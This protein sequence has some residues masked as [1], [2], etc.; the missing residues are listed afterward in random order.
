MPI[1][2]A[3]RKE[4]PCKEWVR[5][6]QRTGLLHTVY[7]VNGDEY[8]GEW[9]NDKRHGRGFMKYSKTG[10]LYEG[11]WK[12]DLKDGYG[13]Y[14]LP[15]GKDGK[16]RKVY[17]GWW[18]NDK[19]HGFGV[20]YR[21]ETEY[22]E[23]EWF[24]GKHSGWGHMVD[25]KDQIYEGEWENGLKH[26]QGMLRLSNENRYEGEF[27]NGMKNGRGSFYFLDTGQRYDGIWLNDIPKCG[28]VKDYGRSSATKP[29]HYIIRKCEL[30]DLDE[31]VFDAEDKF[32]QEVEKV[33]S[34]QD[35]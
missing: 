31:V 19:R 5:K 30:R 16:M 12:N 25:E 21:S 20:F 1:L 23:G 32:L 2:K 18:K 9:L 15:T 22:Y 7:A 24:E 8:R 11:E 34:S 17:A 6:A 14:S 33:N 28:T 26:G 27:L 35:T 3:R 4:P 29:T 13:T 10:G